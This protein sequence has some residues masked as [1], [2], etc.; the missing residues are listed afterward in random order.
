MRAFIIFL[1]LFIVFSASDAQNTKKKKSVKNQT[2]ESTGIWTKQEIQ[3]FYQSW[4]VEDL[5]FP[6]SFEVSLVET[7]PPVNLPKKEE[8]N[9]PQKIQFPVES[10]ENPIFQFFSEN[11]KLILIGLAIL[12]FALYRLRYGSSGYKS[13]GRIFS[14]FKDK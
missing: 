5:Q 3:E 4:I 10:K 12:S 13:S 11:I 2:Q 14:K 7:T 9:S 6:D 1:G 8:S